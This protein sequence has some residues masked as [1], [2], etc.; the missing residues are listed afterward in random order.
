ML[1]IKII[2]YLS[3][4]ILYK[5]LMFIIIGNKVRNNKERRREGERKG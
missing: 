1:K 4:Y 2:I 3:N 5:H